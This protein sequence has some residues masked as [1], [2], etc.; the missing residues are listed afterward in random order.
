MRIRISYA[1]VVATLALLFA[2]SGG[3]L[4]AKHYVINSTKQVNPK[5]LKKLKGKRGKTGKAGTPGATGKE[6]P[7]GKE[8]PQGNEGP[9]GIGPAF[10]AFHEGPVQITSTDAGKPTTVATLSNLPAGQYAIN[11][12]LYVFDTNTTE[13]VIICRLSAEGDTDDVVGRIS[14]GKSDGY[15][16]SIGVY[17]LQVVHQFTSTGSAV[18][19]CSGVSKLA[20]ANHMT[21]TAI[22]VSSLTNTPV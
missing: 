3:A 12:K 18:L 13:D 7:P 4:A 6:G 5:V 22:Q 2:M 15:A 9:A 20:Y 8:G 11:A 16:D 21:I 1:N 19:A 17:P 10:R 14:S